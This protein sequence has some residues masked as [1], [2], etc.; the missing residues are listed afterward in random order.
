MELTYKTTT[1]GLAAY[2]TSNNDPLLHLVQQH[3]NKKKLYYIPKE[4]AKF[5][6]ELDLKELPIEGHKTVV[7]YAKKIKT[8]AKHLALQQMQTR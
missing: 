8:A 7:L 4:A 6:K 3:E 2:L 5:K 1:I